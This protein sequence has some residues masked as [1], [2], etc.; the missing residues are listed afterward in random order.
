M[1]E[2]EHRRP[3]QVSHETFGPNVFLAVISTSLTMLTTSIR[4]L[5]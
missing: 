4:I 2:E 1:D 5:R 3:K